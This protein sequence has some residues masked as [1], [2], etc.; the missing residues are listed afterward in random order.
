VLCDFPGAMLVVSHDADFLKEIQIEE[1]YEL[2]NK[3]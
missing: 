1:Y 2:G 3:R